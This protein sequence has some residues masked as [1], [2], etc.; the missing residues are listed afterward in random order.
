MCHTSDEIARVHDLILLRSGNLDN[1]CMDEPPW[2]SLAVRRTPWV[3]VRRSRAPAGTLAIGVRG[4]AR[5]QRWGGFMD[6]SRVAL[7]KKPSQLR[8][9]LARNFR[10]T[11]PAFKALAFVERALAH[12]ELDWGPA[13]SVGFEL[14]TGDPVT[15]DESDLDLVL[16]APKPVDL[17]MARDLWLALAAAPAKVDVRIETPRCGFSLEEYA[18]AES[19]EILIRAPAG[20]RLV[21]DPWA[22]WDEGGTQ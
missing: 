7:N 5:N 17:T 2:V 12:V 4:T 11:V 15:T 3:V 18:R 8:S 9:S 1:V 10:R 14:A 13:G 19:K 22:L 21:E 20:H 6:L 16:Y